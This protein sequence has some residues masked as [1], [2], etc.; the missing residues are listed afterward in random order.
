MAVTRCAGGSDGK[1]RLRPTA[2]RAQHDQ[3][4][5]AADALGDH[6]P[7]QLVQEH[8]DH[9]HR[10]GDEGRSPPERLRT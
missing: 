10:D 7:D 2:D 4:R 1:L 9:Q 6:R 3:I 8:A 5:A